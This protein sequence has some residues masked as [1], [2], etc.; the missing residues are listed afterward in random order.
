MEYS[1][2]PVGEVCRLIREKQV[3]TV[4]VDDEVL[5]IKEQV[6]LFLKNGKA[7]RD[8]RRILK[9]AHPRRD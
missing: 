4:R 9:H 3:R 8:T 1:E 6:N 5:L 2:L 7:K